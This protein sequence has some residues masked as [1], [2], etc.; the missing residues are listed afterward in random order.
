MH[1][2]YTEIFTVSFVSAAQTI[3]L[4]AGVAIREEIVYRFAIQGYIASKF[5]SNRWGILFAVFI[6]NLLWLMSHQQYENS[7]VGYFHILPL[8][9]ACSLL[10]IRFGITSAIALHF[11]YNLIYIAI[12]FVVP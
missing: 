3:A 9:L 1:D 6:S 5:E 11:L 10:Q 12:S 2:C 7:W 4:F 8:G